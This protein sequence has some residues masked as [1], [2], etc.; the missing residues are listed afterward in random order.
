MKTLH[1][2][3]STTEHN[4]VVPPAMPMVFFD[5]ECPL[6]RREIRHYRRLRGA[7]RIQWVDITRE[8]PLLSSYGLT[9]E[10]AMARF[11]VL[12]SEGRW[13][14]GVWG[15]A[16]V[17]SHLPAYRWLA[18]LLRITR[19]LPVI[20]LAYRRFARWRVR[21]RCEGSSCS[22]AESQL[23][24]SPDTFPK[25]IRQVRFEKDTPYKDEH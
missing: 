23:P 20:D 25:N 13:Q 5:G 2:N 24:A 6:C 9:R 11:H 21:N 17:W 10:R 19:T 8:D 15:F 14:T 4:N 16:E 3:D 22:P 18:G 1:S 12:D 7:D